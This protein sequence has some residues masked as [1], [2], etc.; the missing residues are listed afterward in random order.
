M[1]ICVF[2]GIMHSD[3][4]CNI[5]ED[6]LIP[7]INKTLPNHRFMQ[8]NDPKHPKTCPQTR[9]FESDSL[10]NAVY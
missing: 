5:L 8:G 3:L 10:S 9:S 4:Y 7:F 6:T 2:E 1:K